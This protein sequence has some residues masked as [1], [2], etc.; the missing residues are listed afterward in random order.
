MHSRKSTSFLTSKWNN[1]Q[2]WA[3]LHQKTIPESTHPV[4]D[5]VDQDQSPSLRSEKNF[6][7]W[8]LELSTLRSKLLM[9]L[10]LKSSER[11]SQASF[12]LCFRTSKTAWKL[13]QT[14]I[15]SRLPKW[16]QEL[17]SLAVLQ[18]AGSFCLSEHLNPQTS[19]GKT[20]VCPRFKEYS[21]PWSLLC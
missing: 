3:I 9:K 4:V 21:N 5:Y 16:L 18:T 14:T 17:F 6:S 11:V 8:R 2:R 19:T 10:T 7:R 13:Q 15:G 1:M 20:W 12:S